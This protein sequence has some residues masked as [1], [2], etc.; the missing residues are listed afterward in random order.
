MKP[1]EGV[2]YIYIADIRLRDMRIYVV[3]WQYRA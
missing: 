2:G 1:F 3:E